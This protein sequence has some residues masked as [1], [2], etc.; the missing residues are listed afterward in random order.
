MAQA[1]AVNST[2]GHRPPATNLLIEVDDILTHLAD[3]I[4][5]LRLAA[6]GQGQG[7]GRNALARGASDAEDLLGDAKKLLGDA[8]TTSA[9]RAGR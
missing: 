5:L 9:G 8:I 3:Q 6:E 1:K 4:G 2:V 7:M